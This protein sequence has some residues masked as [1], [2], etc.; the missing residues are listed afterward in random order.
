MDKTSF[1]QYR[2]ALRYVKPYWKRLLLAMIFMLGVAG[3]TSAL[4]YLV[5]PA[6]DGIFVE[7]NMSMLKLMPFA[8]LV[9]FSLKGIFNFSQEYFMNYVGQRVIMDIRQKLFAHMQRLSVSYFKK[10]TVG[11]VITRIIGD[12]AVLQS[13][14]SR[15]LTSLIKDFFTAFGLI[16]VVFY[17]DLFL[18]SIA[19]VSIPLILI[20][21]LRFGLK[22]KKY[23]Y[24]AQGIMGGMTSFLKE[25]FS[26]LRIVKV[27]NIEVTAEERFHKEN[28][29][30]FK[31]FMS[32]IK[33]KASSVLVIDIL[34]ATAIAFV[35]WYGGKQVIAG[36]RTPGD[37][38][39]F[40]TALILMYE[41]IKRMNSSYSAIQEGLGASQRIFKILD[42][43]TE[44]DNQG[45]FE[46]ESFKD[47][48][49]F[50]QLFFKYSEDNC[51]LKN[52]NLTVKRGEKIGIVGFSGEGK[53][54]LV[55]LI[56]RFFDVS[57]G[58]ILI[59]GRD[60]KDFT[61]K[62]LRKQIAMVTQE[63]I[64]FNTEIRDN[65][66]VGKPDAMDADISEAAKNAFAHDFITKFPED[67]K[68]VIGEMG[69][70]IS[71]GE[72]QRI[73]I[74]RAFIK[75]API[76]ILDE[77]T[78]A[79]DSRSEKEVQN[80]LNVLMEGRT[81]FIVAHR[82][83]TLSEVDR[84]IVIKNGTISETGT[85]EELLRK[86]EDYYALYKMQQQREE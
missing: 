14:V 46:L 72:R 38:F 9:S 34:A 84:I 15:S 8:I 21:I 42:E 45:T 4:A 35:I 76:L 30:Y 85:H 39:S 55:S 29:G 65:I 61:L 31:N 80:A 2:R 32:Q 43:E 79:L 22:I 25:H 56:P 27:F 60:I 68:T 41:P 82:L 83:S 52:I 10:T 59:D 50:K 18:A 62:S 40:I 73:A 54:T 51:V 13:S 70:R 67:Y 3:S 37:F 71:G 86:K 63:S 47:S 48:I 24:K 7:K 81:C 57:A 77:A 20:P 69:E 74:A 49:E 58:A 1:Q 44:I 12:V 64:L 23:S 53:S 11:E 36:T 75:N 6:L 5:K 26:G 33:V 19:F 16:A 66:L 28:L 17:R 78:S